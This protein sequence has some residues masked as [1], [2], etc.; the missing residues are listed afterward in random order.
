MVGLVRRQGGRRVA[1]GH[2]RRRV[3]GAP[4]VPARVRPPRA[5]AAAGAAGPRPRRRACLR[6]LVAA[7]GRALGVATRADLADHHRLRGDQVQAVVA[8]TGLVEVEVEG[9][10]RARLGGARGP[11]GP[12]DA[13]TPTDDAPVPLRL[14]GVGSPPPGAAASASPIASRPT[15]PQPSAC[16]GTSRCR[17]WPAAASSTPPS[18]PA[19]RAG[20]SWPSSSRSTCAPRRPWRRRCARP[21]RGSGATRWRSATSEP[22]AVAPALAAELA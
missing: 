13:G 18:T 10:R 11:D 14:A 3:R 4:R 9:W 22:A 1:P 6:A 8:D 19:A 12:G 7:A 5:G 17:C 2:R 15:C 21:R 20:P 16:T